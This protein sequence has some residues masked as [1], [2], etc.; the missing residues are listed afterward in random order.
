[1]KYLEQYLRLFSSYSVDN[2][3]NSWKSEGK[4]EQAT[5]YNCLVE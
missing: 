2:E 3:E 5:F 1:M 4:I